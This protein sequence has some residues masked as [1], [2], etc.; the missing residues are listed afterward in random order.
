MVLASGCSE[1]YSTEQRRDE[2]REEIFASLQ[3]NVERGVLVTTAISCGE[4]GIAN[5]D[6]YYYARLT[7]SEFV[8]YKAILVPPVTS[9]HRAVRAAF[10]PSLLQSH[11]PRQ[12]RSSAVTPA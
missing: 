4:N 8:D 2:L 9:S 10:S 11:L 7:L 1:A 3:H 5:R 12:N 6:D